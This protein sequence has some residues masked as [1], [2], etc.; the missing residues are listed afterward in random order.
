M[1][2][3]NRRSNRGMNRRSKRSKRNRR[4]KRSNM[5]GGSGS[6]S[7]AS[8]KISMFVKNVG[9]ESVSLQWWDNSNNAW[10]A[11]E[12]VVPPG[13]N[14]TH[15]SDVGTPWRAIITHQKPGK[16]LSWVLGDDGSSQEIHVNLTPLKWS[17]TWTA[18]PSRVESGATDAKADDE[19]TELQQRQVHAREM[20]DKS[21]APNNPYERAGM[22]SLLYTH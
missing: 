1:G 15:L 22:S 9:E 17:L 18:S 7:A 14:D 2:R 19:M 11:W 3:K 8:G 20:R 13:K 6:G 16:E 5:R 4:T 10:S 21:R 12:Y